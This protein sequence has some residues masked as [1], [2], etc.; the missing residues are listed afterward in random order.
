MDKKIKRLYVADLGIN[1]N[2]FPV[3]S[4][5]NGVIEEFKVNGEMAPV[6]W[7]RKDN[8]EYNGK[9]VIMIEYYK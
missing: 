2:R 6:R 7:F 1:G 8:V 9:Y 5:E 3:D 4:D